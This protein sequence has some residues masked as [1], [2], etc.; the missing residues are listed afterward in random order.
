MT[1]LCLTISCN[2]LI[3]CLRSLRMRTLL[4]SRWRALHRGG[5][6]IPP[7]PLLCYAKYQAL[8]S[9]LKARDFKQG[10]TKITVILVPPS[11][12]VS[13]KSG[14]QP[15]ND[16]AD[17]FPHQMVWT[18]HLLYVFIPPRTSTNTVLVALKGEMLYYS[19]IIPSRT[20][21][22]KI[23][24]WIVITAY[25][26]KAFHQREPSAGAELVLEPVSLFRKKLIVTEECRW[27]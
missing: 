24:F 14:L 5:E 8:G 2:D 4:F 11:S 19:D 21:C 10:D 23:C 15:P 7:R 6:L 13:P 1:S 25:N 20:Q 3:P 12:M 16:A 18:S 27:T 17:R 26:F 9:W 22:Q